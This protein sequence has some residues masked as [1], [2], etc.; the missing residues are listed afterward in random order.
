MEIEIVTLVVKGN[1]QPTVPLDL[2]DQIQVGRRSF[3]L[4][5]FFD[6]KLSGI[7]LTEIIL[8]VRVINGQYLIDISICEVELRC[9]M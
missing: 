7:H 1:A 6:L 2:Y 5:N 4:R 3:A 9:Y 8:K